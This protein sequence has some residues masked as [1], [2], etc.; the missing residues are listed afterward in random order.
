MREL[1]MYLASGIR[2]PKPEWARALVERE[3]HLDANTF[4]LMIVASTKGEAAQELINLGLGEIE[5]VKLMKVATW[6][7]GRTPN[8]VR[9]LFN[10]GLFRKRGVWIWHEI[11]KNKAVVKVEKNAEDVVTVEP[12][13]RFRLY[14]GEERLLVET[15]N[16]GPGRIHWKVSSDGYRSPTGYVAGLSLFSTHHSYEA[17]DKNNYSVR[18]L[19]TTLPGWEHAKWRCESEKAAHER[20]EHLLE[21]FLARIGAVWAE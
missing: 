8:E 18:A 5:T 20:A 9:I 3:H 17:E 14:P 1:R 16:P 7:N 15:P 21:L 13:A 2:P 10:A 12:V 19:K 11:L 6:L 4:H